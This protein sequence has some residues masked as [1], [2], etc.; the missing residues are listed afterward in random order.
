MITHLLSAL[1]STVLPR[2]LADNIETLGQGA[3]GI[4]EMWGIVKATFPHTNEGSNGV[5]FLSL[6]IAD[7]I[8]K[9]IGAVAVIMIIYGG[10]RMIFTGEE[11][12][13]EAKKIVLY[14]V[15][16][17]IAALCAQ[18]AVTFAL[19]VVGAAAA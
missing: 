18:A 4:T 1:A 14:A 10:L 6:K 11:G 19:Q 13:N 3:P 7:F 9:I 5:P 2:A 15:L 17:L 12:L 16:G 8:L